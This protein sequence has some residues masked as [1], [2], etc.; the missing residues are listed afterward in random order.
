MD[1]G[2]REMNPVATTIVNPRKEYRPKGTFEP[3]TSYS[4]VL[5][6]NDK[7]TRARRKENGQTFISPQH[8]RHFYSPVPRFHIQTDTS[9]VDRPWHLNR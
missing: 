6:A 8:H 9:S 3:A 2:N 1:N 5:Y 7:A 4:P